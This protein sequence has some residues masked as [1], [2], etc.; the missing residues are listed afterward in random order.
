MQSSTVTRLQPSPDARPPSRRNAPTVTCRTQASCDRVEADRRPRSAAR[1]GGCRGRTR[2]RSGGSP[3]RPRR[4]GPA[5]R[6]PTTVA[7]AERGV[8]GRGQRGVE[9]DRSSPSIGRDRRGR[10]G[11]PACP[12]ASSASRPSRRAGSGPSRATRS[13]PA[14]LGMRRR[15]PRRRRAGRPAS[16]SR[17][18]RA[19]TGT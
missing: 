18:R 10:S 13:R 9:R 2:T 6:R 17:R 5:T 15:G 14:V 16:S 8:E 11:R 4:S 19:P 1:R 7:A 3:R 12:G